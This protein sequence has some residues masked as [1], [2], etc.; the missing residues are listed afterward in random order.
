MKFFKDVK[1]ELSKVHWP[2]RKYMV[3]YTVA[4]MGFT[5]FF[6]LYFYGISAVV[7]LIKGLR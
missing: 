7:A 6:A 4:T 2:D 5:I 1:G 3:K